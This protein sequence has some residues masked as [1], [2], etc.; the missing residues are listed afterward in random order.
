MCA[1][2]DSS[3]TVAITRHVRPGKEG[4]FAEVFEQMT[5]A[6]SAFDGHLGAGHIRAAQ[7]GG[8]HVIVYRFDT[9]EHLDA[10]QESAER[11]RL[12]H[13]LDG[14]IEGEERVERSTGLEFWFADPSCPAGPSPRP[15]KQALV[16]WVGLFPTVYLLGLLFGRFWDP[17]PDLGRIMISTAVTVV[18]MTAA[19]MPLLTRLLRGFLRPRAKTA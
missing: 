10:W 16:T 1:Y 13:K 17:L 19:V 3:V 18:L 11:V 7:P 6:A 9:P 4:E 5:A 2:K 14:V 8:E 12:L 15:W